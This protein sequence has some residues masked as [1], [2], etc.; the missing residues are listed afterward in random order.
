MTMSAKYRN[1]LISL[2]IIIIWSGIILFLS[3]NS[4]SELGTGFALYSWVM[5]TRF[6]AIIAGIL[7][8]VIRIT[9]IMK[10]KIDLWYFLPGMFNV[11]LGVIGVVVFLTK[12]AS[13]SIFHD[14][15]PNL[16]LGV[17]ILGDIFFF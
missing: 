16:L 15:L 1:L 13:A 9:R 2:F 17:L 5:L 7:S 8:L 12:N 10:R 6:V 14:L 4:K 11:C 3:S